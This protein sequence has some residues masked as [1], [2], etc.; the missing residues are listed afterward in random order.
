ML[1]ASLLVALGLH[2]GSKGWVLLPEMLWVCH[3]ASFVLALG[4]LLGIPAFAAAGFLLHVSYGFPSYVLDV[5]ATGVTTP[6]SVLVHGLTLVGGA[7]A[8]WRAGWPP[9]VAAP[10]WAFY[11]MWVPVCYWFTP[12]ALN[13]NLA[14]APWPPLAG[15]FPRL[16]MSWAANALQSLVS[17]LIADY[18]LR[19]WP[20]PAR[21]MRAS[22]NAVHL[23]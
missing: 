23:S 21:S 7:F 5:V 22:P 13:V 4:L 1:G 2:A 15:V 19:R 9:G 12:P 17:F 11:L 10:A 8:V 3:I 20:S 6:T 18:I 14:H 16:W